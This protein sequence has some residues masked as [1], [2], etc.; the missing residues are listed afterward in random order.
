MPLE[1]RF[2]FAVFAASIAAVVGGCSAGPPPQ[3]QEVASRWISLFNGQDLDGWQVKI[4][5]Y[6]VGDN[7]NRTFRVEDGILKV[8]YDDYELFDG[9][10]GHLFYD[11][12]FSH[13]R[14]RVEYRFVGDQVPGGPGWAYRN[15]GV[16]LHSQSPQSMGRD[17]DF[18]VSIEAQ[19]LGGNSTDDRSTANVCTPGTHIAMDGRLITRHCTNSSS[20]TYHGDAWAIIEVEVRGNELIRHLMDGEVVMEYQNPQLDGNDPDAQRLIVG[21]KT[22]LDR[23]YIALQAESHPVEFRRVELLPLN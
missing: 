1:T 3:S 16:M 4:R 15:S 20:R 21:G 10:F 2:Y 5:G 11:T 18:P 17:Q 14:L 12:P 19:F 13:Y 23:G 8:A 6:E 9:E 22:M 7:Y